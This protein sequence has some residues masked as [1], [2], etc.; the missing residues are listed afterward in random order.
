MVGC[1]HAQ[2]NRDRRDRRRSC[3]A[4]GD[5][6][7]PQQPAKARLAG[8][9]HSG[10]RGG[11]RHR[12]GD[13]SGGRVEAQRLALAGALHA[14]R[15]RRFAARQD[16]AGTYPAGAEGRGRGGRD[17]HAGRGA[18]RRGD[19]LDGARDGRGEWPQR[20]LGAADLADARAAT[21]S[22][23]QLQAVD[24]CQIRREGRG[25][26][27]AVRRSAGPC[28]GAVDRREASLAPRADHQGRPGAG[29]DPG[30]RPEPAGACR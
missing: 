17:A 12:R 10:D 27:R 11:L 6:G 8:A 20:Q 7:G 14:R 2:G 29:R 30:A 13:A 5:R 3:S 18:A 9:D 4:R 15:R 23:P 19:P 25:H 26:R 1:R 21:P 22:G 24:R 28:R 16:S